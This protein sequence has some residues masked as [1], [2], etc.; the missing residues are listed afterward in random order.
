[1]VTFPQKNTVFI[2]SHLAQQLPEVK[3]KP[4]LQP[5]HFLFSNDFLYLIYYLP[6]QVMQLLHAYSFHILRRQSVKWTRWT[7]VSITRSALLLGWKIASVAERVTAEG[8]TWDFS[9]MPNYLGMIPGYSVDYCKVIFR[10]FSSV[11]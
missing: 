8:A 4:H 11:I 5:R 10:F 2:S 6:L 7:G 3:R 1:M 9:S